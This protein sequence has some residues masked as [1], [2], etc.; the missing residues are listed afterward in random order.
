MNDEDLKA[1]KDLEIEKKV[2]LLEE[3]VRMHCEI[4]VCSTY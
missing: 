4:A 2:L 3:E 1:I